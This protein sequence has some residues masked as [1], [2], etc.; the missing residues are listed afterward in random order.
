MVTRSFDPAA[1][2][3]MSDEPYRERILD[4]KTTLA[5]VLAR[6]QIRLNQVLDLVPGSMVT[7]EKLCDE[8]LELEASGIVMATG[9]AVKVGDK[10][11]IRIRRIGPPDE[12]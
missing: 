1:D 4:I 7:F 8:P 3:S 12:E 11:G 2:E 5:V 6:R 9:E 10:F